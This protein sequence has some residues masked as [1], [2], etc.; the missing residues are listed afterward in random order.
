MFA[1][2]DL[3]DDERLKFKL[4]DV[5]KDELELLGVI[6]EISKLLDGRGTSYASSI[7]SCRLVVVLEFDKVDCR[8]IER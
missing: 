8:L 7:L 5:S 6:L 3:F 4:S 2:D 1:S